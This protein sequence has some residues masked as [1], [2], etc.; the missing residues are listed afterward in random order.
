[1]T[2]CYLNQ[3]NRE[4][5]IIADNFHKY[6]SPGRGQEKNEVV[7]TEKTMH[8]IF[9]PQNGKD[10]PLLNFSMEISN[11]F[12]ESTFHRAKFEEQ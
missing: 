4:L 9:F 6:A 7:K 10:L 8:Y 2:T 11:Q 3:Y 12:H 5:Y 1:M